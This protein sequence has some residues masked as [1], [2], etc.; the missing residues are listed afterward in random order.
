MS[1]SQIQR[2]V[3]LLA[4]SIEQFESGPRP[5]QQRERLLAEID[6]RADTVKIRLFDAAKY[7]RRIELSDCLQDLLLLVFQRELHHAVE[8]AIDTRDASRWAG[9]DKEVRREIDEMRARLAQLQA[10]LAE[11]ASTCAPE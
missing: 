5:E 10:Q 7:R 4:R 8:S 3:E 2:E 6:Q 11:D 1:R 9:L